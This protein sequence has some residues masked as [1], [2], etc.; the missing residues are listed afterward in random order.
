[1][2]EAITTARN[3]PVYTTGAALVRYGVMPALNIGATNGTPPTRVQDPVRSRLTERIQQ[4]IEA[5]RRSPRTH[6][7]LQRL[8]DQTIYRSITSPLSDYRA[9][10]YRKLAKYRGVKIVDPYQDVRLVEFVFN[11]PPTYN[12]HEGYDKA[13]FRT[14]LHDILPQ[15]ILSRQKTDRVEEAIAEGLRRERAYLTALLTQRQLKHLGV[16]RNQYSVPETTVAIQRFGNITT[17]S[18]YLWEYL[19]AQAWLKYQETT[20]LYASM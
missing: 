9:D 11:L 2:R 10:I 8:S 20:P 17:A 3:D 15:Q 12:L 16:V 7:S 6:G 18:T 4:R 5:S 14:A 13:I 1:V 19:S